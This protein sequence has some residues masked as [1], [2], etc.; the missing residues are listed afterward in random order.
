MASDFH[1]EFLGTRGSLPVSGPEHVETGG[2]TSS[3]RV[4]AGTRELILDAGSGLR[5]YGRRLVESREP[6][7]ELERSIFLSHAHFDHL[8]GLPYF[9]PL[10]DE[11]ASIRIWGP[12]TPQVDSFSQIVEQFVH[13]PYFPVPFY[14]FAADVELSTI[15]D[16]DVLHWRRGES[17]PTAASSEPIDDEDVEVELRTLRGYSHPTSGVYHY[18]IVVG[19]RSLVYAT[20][21]EAYRQGDRRL[22]EFAQGADVL[23]HDAMYTRDEYAELPVPTQGFGHS[24]VRAATEVAQRADVDRLFLFHHAPTRSDDELDELEALGRSRFEGTA[25]ARD[26]AVVDI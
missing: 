2:A 8:I 10:H 25:V 23:I 18:K 12:R 11:D 1:L 22:I 13:P 6:G 21:T 3:V 19:D 26:G 14:E 15:R 5:A 4:R 17:E 20:D 9:A 7:T 24:T 16:R